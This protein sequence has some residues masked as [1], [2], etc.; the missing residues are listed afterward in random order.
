MKKR[1]I[2]INSVS[3]RT[4]TA[5]RIAMAGDI[6][7][8]IPSVYMFSDTLLPIAVIYMLY[9]ILIHICCSGTGRACAFMVQRSY[10]QKKIKETVNIYRAAFILNAGIGFLLTAVLFIFAK[11]TAALLLT[12]SGDSTD[13]SRLAVL[14]KIFSPAVLCE[15]IL[16]AYR[17]SDLGMHQSKSYIRSVVIEQVLR[18]LLAAGVPLYMT[19]QPDSDTLLNMEIAVGMLTAAGFIEIIHYASRTVGA[20]QG[21]QMDVVSKYL[22]PLF[23]K[24]VSCTVRSLPEILIFMID[25]LLVIPCCIYAD[26]DYVSAKEAYLTVIYM[27]YTLS[28]LPNTICEL[29]T[30]SHTQDLV[31]AVRLKSKRGI[32]RTMASCSVVLLMITVPIGVFLAFNGEALYSAVFSYSMMEYA[33]AY[34]ILIGIHIALSALSSASSAVVITLG[35]EKSTCAYQVFAA[36]VKAAL[37]FVLTK[38][39]GFLT[40]PASS[41]VYDILVLFLNSAKVKNISG[42][43][44]G[45]I[46]IQAGQILLAGTAMHGILFILSLFGINGVNTDRITS[47]WQCGVM[48][49]SGTVLYIIALDIMRVI[50]RKKVH[51][52]P[53]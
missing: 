24:S 32:E 9:R 48:V 8:L 43:D 1:K 21:M 53:A 50:R 35:K 19:L 3:L 18:I 33:D 52:D 25:A 47:L 45:S 20:F 12:S 4:Q 30:Y 42:F 23:T 5:D 27:T 46:R 6:L 38:E 41:I 11:E 37:M 34:M 29:V 28:W 44:F 15:F 22:S 16:S 39:Y 2:S 31:K 36:V 13:I 10:D 7:V 14:L 49:A 40:I 26:V 17:G 51:H